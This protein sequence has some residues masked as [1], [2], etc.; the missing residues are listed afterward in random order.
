VVFVHA[1]RCTKSFTFREGVRTIRG[2]PAR[3]LRIIVA[4]SLLALGGVAVATTPVASRPASP[5][6]DAAEHWTPARRAAAIPRDLVVDERGLGFLRKPGGQ[7]E[8]Y[9]H[10][11]PAR[12]EAVATPARGPQT[13]AGKPGSGDR[14]GP[15]VSIVQPTAATTITSF[16]YTFKANVADPSGIKS[17]TF[18]LTPSGGTGQSFRASLVSGVWSVTFSNISSGSWSWKVVAIDGANNK[19]TTASV[20]FTV[21]TSGG[22]GSTGTVTDADWPSSLGSVQKAVGRIYFEMPGNQALTIWKAYV[23]SGTTVT[24]GVSGRSIILTAAHCV[25]DDVNKA[26]ARNVLF[27][28]DQ[29]SSGPTDSNC[30]ND[31]H[32]CWKPKYGA[33]DAN[34]ASRS[35]PDNIPWDYAYYV[36]DDTDAASRGGNATGALDALANMP[37]SFSAPDTTAAADAIGYSYS[38]DPN[39]R[40]CSERLGATGAANWWLGT[41][42]L[43]GGASGGPWLQPAGTGAGPII[44][45]NSWGY[46]TSPGMAGP[47]LNGTSASCVFTAAKS[48]TSNRT[49]TC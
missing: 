17:V 1:D 27:I 26:F 6:G 10:A 40:Y 18:T 16:P 41:C 7:L 34:W 46:T 47:K 4:V 32:G 2:V 11:T 31:V 23:C 30:G 9:G 8:P 22:G 12:A 13:K 37:V 36:V 39:L 38:K 24:D 43:S 20:G 5:G 15:S 25:Y 19:T 48:A 28:P 42:A 14:T 3:L 29:D 49:V 21:D 35:W 45:V 33:V 44:S